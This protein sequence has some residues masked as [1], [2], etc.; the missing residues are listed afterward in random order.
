[1]QNDVIVANLETNISRVLTALEK[2]TKQLKPD[3]TELLKAIRSIKLEQNDLSSIDVALAEIK[4]ILPSLKPE[5]IDTGKAEI[6]AELTE[7]KEGVASIKIPKLGSLEEVMT[8]I[9]KTVREFKIEIPEQ[10]EI[11]LPREYPL[12]EDQIKQLTPKQKDYSERYRKILDKL[13]EIRNVAGGG[14]TDV[15]GLKDIKNAKVNP[16]TEETLQ[17][18]QEWESS[19]ADLTSPRFYYLMSFI[20]RSEKWKISRIS[21]TSYESTY[22]L[23]EKDLETAWSN[24]ES[25]TYSITY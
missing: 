12:P 25:L 7:I 11:M 21:K 6:V 19:K 13:E 4:K 15:V 9:L 5:K 20:P 3:D 23:G 14:G 22:A 2:A 17:S 18:L 1:M 16:A 8:E 24:R 10:K